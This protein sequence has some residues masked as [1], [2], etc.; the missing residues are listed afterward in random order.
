MLYLVIIYAYI[1]YIQLCIFI[2]VCL[3]VYNEK[4]EKLLE[5]GR[6]SMR[7][8]LGHSRSVLPFLLMGSGKNRQ[9]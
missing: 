5:P 8:K 4:V 7:K 2:C 6:E 9:Q 3:Y 1:V